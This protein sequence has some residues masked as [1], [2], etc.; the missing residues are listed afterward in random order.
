MLSPCLLSY[1]CTLQGAL[2]ACCLAFWVWKA[3]LLALLLQ[4]NPET[5]ARSLNPKLVSMAMGCLLPVCVTHSVQ[6]ESSCSR[7]D[8]YCMCCSPG[9]CL[10]TCC[11]LRLLLCI[12]TLN[13]TVSASMLCLWTSKR[14]LTQY[15]G[16]CSLSVVS[17]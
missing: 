11:S 8:T 2:G 12:Y 1:S 15:V 9:H 13:T 10:Q 16:A 5:P 6:A 14:R 4:R 7:R 17:S 3:L